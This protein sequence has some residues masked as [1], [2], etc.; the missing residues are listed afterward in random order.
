MIETKP[1]W[2]LLLYNSERRQNFCTT[3]PTLSMLCTY[4]TLLS[5]KRKYCTNYDSV[6]QDPKLQDKQLTKIVQLDVTYKNVIPA[7]LT[8]MKKCESIWNSH[9]GWFSV[10]KQFFVLNSMAAPLIYSAPYCAG[11]KQRWQK[12]GEI[13]QMRKTVVVDRAI[14]EWTFSITI[15]LINDGSLPFYTDFCRLNEVTERDRYPIPRT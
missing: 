10:A 6:Q 9:V 13:E 1:L 2:A 14:P 12:H 5:Q 4:V 15:M 7:F 8:M 11:H 3:N